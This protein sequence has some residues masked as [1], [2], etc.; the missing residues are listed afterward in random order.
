MFHDK[1]LASIIVDNRQ[2]AIPRI[3]TKIEVRGDQIIERVK[4]AK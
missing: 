3:E 4:G 1:K 2:I